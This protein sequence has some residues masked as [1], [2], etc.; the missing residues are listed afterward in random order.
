MIIWKICKRKNSI[1][2]GG[3]FI[4]LI[5]KEFLKKNIRS[6]IL[7][8]QYRVQWTIFYDR[9]QPILPRPMED[10]RYRSIT[11]AQLWYEQTIAP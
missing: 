9:I 2:K 6:W 10:S 7:K 8:E 3:S 1:E 4:Q 11:S 5:S